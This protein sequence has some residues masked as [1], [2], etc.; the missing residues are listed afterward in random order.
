MNDDLPTARF[1][2]LGSDAPTASLAVV[3]PATAPRRG[4]RGLIGALVAV[5]AATVLAIAA[6]GVVAAAPTGYDATPAGTTN[7]DLGPSPVSAHPSHVLQPV[8]D[9]PVFEPVGE[10]TGTYDSN[11]PA[12]T[13]TI[14]DFSVSNTAVLC[15]TQ[16]PVYIPQQISFTWNVVGA[17]RVFFGVDTIDAQAEPMFVDLPHAGNSHTEFPMGYEDYAYS[18]P[19]PSHQYTLT[20]VD[21]QGHAVSRTVTVVNNGDTSY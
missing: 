4:S 20:A 2:Q 12:E 19:V 3:A 7:A 11:P 14:I 6:V 18:C 21:D 1:D 15:N 9:G 10:P 17:E 13:V 5:G 16:S 8:V